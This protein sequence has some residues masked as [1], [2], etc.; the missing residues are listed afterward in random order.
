MSATFEGEEGAKLAPKFRL[1]K[2]AGIT[3]LPRLESY[4]ELSDAWTKP[5]LSQRVGLSAFAEK[6]LSNGVAV[7]AVAE[8]D[9][10]AGLAAF[11]CNDLLR[12]RAYLTH[13]AVGPAYRGH[14]LGKALIN[15]ATKYSR[16]MGMRLMELEVYRDN[17]TAKRL[18]RSCGFGESADPKASSSIR[19]VCSL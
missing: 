15:Y 8:G 1:K 9:I 5:P 17:E 6:I 10:D 13:L 18:Y 2:L 7:L 16:S 14:G 12:H 11:Y 19:M 4:L 3:D